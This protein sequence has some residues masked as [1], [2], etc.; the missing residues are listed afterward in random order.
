MQ[1]FTNSLQDIG[2]IFYCT[3]IQISIKWPIIEGDM[4]KLNDSFVKEHIKKGFPSNFFVGLDL[5][6]IQLLKHLTLQQLEILADD[7][8]YIENYLFLRKTHFS[9][10]SGRKQTKLSRNQLEMVNELL[11]TE[12]PERYKLTFKTKNVKEKNRLGTNEKENMNVDFSGYLVGRNINLIVRNGREQRK[13]SA[14]KL[15]SIEA[16]TPE[17]FYS[18]LQNKYYKNEVNKEIE[19]EQKAKEEYELSL[20]YPDITLKNEDG[21]VS[22]FKSSK[23]DQTIIYEATNEINILSQ[24]IELLELDY[25]DLMVTVKKAYKE[26]IYSVD[27]EDLKKAIKYEE[28]IS[29]KEE[30]LAINQ[31]V[32]KS[33]IYEKQLK[34]NR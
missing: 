13:I 2:T 6:Q 12:T 32:L 33:I 20:S 8:D 30:E 5:E 29:D 31:S 27:N 3:L 21:Q 10:S 26:S 19:L 18:E 1:L 25:R 15:L 28:K 24:E 17:E 22:D 11:T 9:N 34:N 16:M 7:V 4:K 23:S 14:S